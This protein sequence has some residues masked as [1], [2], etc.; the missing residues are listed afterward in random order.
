M[1]PE[2]T[3]SHSSYKP[4]EIQA[5]AQQPVLSTSLRKASGSNNVRKPTNVTLSH[6]ADEDLLSQYAE[7]DSTLGNMY[8]IFFNKYCMPYIC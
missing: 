8:K 4:A 7:N 2:E 3:Y 6:Q 5:P 1:L